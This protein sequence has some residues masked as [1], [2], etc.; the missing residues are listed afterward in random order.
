VLFRSQEIVKR[1]I[2]ENI[3]GKEQLE[4]LQA[5]SG[6]NTDFF[7][8]LTTIGKKFMEGT[9]PRLGGVPPGKLTPAESIARARELM[10][11]PGYIDGSM[12]SAT[13]ERLDKEIAALYR[14][15]QAPQG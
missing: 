10:Q 1:M 8:L 4:R 14:A 5:A 7:D 11:T 6:N 15:A 9:L 12:P 2:S 3:A 13:K